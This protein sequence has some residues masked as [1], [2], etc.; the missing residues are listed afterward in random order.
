MRDSIHQSKDNPY[1]KW[2]GGIYGP[3]TIQIY[4]SAEPYDREGSKYT[5]NLSFVISEN[6][7]LVT[8][9]KKNSY[10]VWEVTKV[11]WVDYFLLRFASKLVVTRLR[12][13]Y[14]TAILS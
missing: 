13:F 5:Q 3:P 11:W 8:G 10:G 2:G 12:C 6:L 1:S 7:K 4:F 14:V 9:Q